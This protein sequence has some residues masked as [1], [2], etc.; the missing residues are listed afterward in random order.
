MDFSEGMMKIGLLSKSSE[1]YSNSRI[2][3]EA[4]SLNLDIIHIDYTNCDLILN[5]EKPD[6]LYNGQSLSQLDAVIPRVGIYKSIYGMAVLRH[7]EAMHVYSLN[8]SLGIARARDKLR[9]L[10]ILSKK[11]L[12]FPN[13]A[14]SNDSLN[15]SK[16]LDKVGGTPVIIKLTEGLQGK[17]TVLAE[18]KQSAKS[19][20]EAFGLTNTSLI[21]QE[22]IKESIGTDVRVFILNGKVIGSMIRSSNGEDFRSNL[23]L[24]GEAKK[25][26]LTPREREIA[27]KAAKEFKLNVAGIDIL[28]S[29][30][31]PLI[32]EVNSCPG[33]E[34]I[35]RAMDKNI[36]RLILEFVMSE[37]EKV[38]SK[39]SYHKR[40][41]L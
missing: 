14:I 30:N 12:P 34:G 35:E 21:L 24:G 3:E 11:S 27:V 32:L 8:S 6:I 23:H 26:K 13:S 17:G 38:K 15:A 39:P 25:V 16:L 41:H 1:N 10:Q 5:N 7:F 31:G 20:I 36:A 33:L 28:R 2:L 19:I 40:T 4:Q 37:V 18:T 29:D 9:T 22:F